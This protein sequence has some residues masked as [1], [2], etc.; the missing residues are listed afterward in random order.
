MI[1][2]LESKVRPFDVLAGFRKQRNL[3]YVSI[4]CIFIDAL[5]GGDSASNIPPTQPMVKRLTCSWK[6]VGSMLLN[7]SCPNKSTFKAKVPS[8]D[9]D[10]RSL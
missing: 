3:R 10:V 7:F 9:S 5:L 2:A 8:V 6:A 4:I 1:L